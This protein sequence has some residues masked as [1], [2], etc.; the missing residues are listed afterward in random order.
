M[1]RRTGALVGPAVLLAVLATATHGQE[2][3]PA[4]GILGRDAPKWDVPT[5]INLPAETEDLEIQDLLGRVVY[6]YCF[7]SWC[8][9][10][11]RRGFPTLTTLIDRFDG[12][13]DVR[14]ISRLHFSDVII[15][16]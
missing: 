14:Q 13:D 9:G 11:H 4:R 2:A 5:W 1:R 15:D 6:L 12:V 16:L 10:C 8:P 3:K 7:Q